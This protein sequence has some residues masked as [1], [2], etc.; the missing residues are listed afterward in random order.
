[1]TLSFLSL[2]NPCSSGEL[3]LPFVSRFL[4]QFQETGET[5]KEAVER[6]TGQISSEESKNEICP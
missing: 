6:V 3:C 4:S 2:V 1:M 5:R